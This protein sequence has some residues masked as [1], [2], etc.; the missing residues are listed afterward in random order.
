MP[1]SALAGVER[2][3]QKSSEG[4]LIRT[5][6]ASRNR[7]S[8]GILECATNGIAHWGFCMTASSLEAKHRFG[9]VQTPTTSSMGTPTSCATGVQISV[10]TVGVSIDTMMAYRAPW[11]LRSR[12]FISFHQPVTG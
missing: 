1:A 2:P 6:V 9:T 12:F 5:C 3:G 11:S 10:V 7:T 8:F 4:F